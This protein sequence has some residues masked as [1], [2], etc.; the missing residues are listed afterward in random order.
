MANSSDTEMLVTSA[1][2]GKQLESFRASDVGKYLQ[3]RALRVYNAAIEEFASVSP[4]DSQ[5]IT[6]IQ[7]DMW[8]ASAFVQWVEEG[9]QEGLTSLNILE[10]L[11]DDVPPDGP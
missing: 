11:D 1:M 10:G 4:Q 5:K 7:A 8:K 9:I 6:Q 2:L 3:A